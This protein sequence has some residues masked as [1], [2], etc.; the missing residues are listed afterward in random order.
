MFKKHNKESRTFRLTIVTKIHFYI[1][2]STRYG[3]SLHVSGNTD[4]LGNN[5]PSK[6]LAL[7]YLS[8]EYWY[9]VTETE[10]PAD[11][12]DIIYRY[13]LKDENRMGK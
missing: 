11:Q 5:D 13:H 4:A 1:R 10:T 9:G 8:D 7:N 12:D 3:Q 2:F 6:A